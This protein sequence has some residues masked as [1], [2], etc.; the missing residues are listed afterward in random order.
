MIE[1]PGY[2]KPKINEHDMHVIYHNYAW[3]CGLHSGLTLVRY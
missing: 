2:E 3:L 1:W